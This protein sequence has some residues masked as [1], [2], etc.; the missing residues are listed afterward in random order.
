VRYRTVLVRIGLALGLVFAT[1]AAAAQEQARP[2]IDLSTPEPPAE[3]GSSKPRQFALG[4]GLLKEHGFGVV[5]R[6]RFDH[7]ALDA[8]YGLMPVFVLWRDADLSLV[9]VNAGPVI[10]FNDALDRFQNGVRIAGIY[11]QIL[12]PG[13]GFGWVGE[14]TKRSFAVGLGAGIQYYPDSDGRIRRHFHYGPGVDVV[15]ARVQ[16]YFGVNLLWYL[17]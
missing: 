5:G 16:L 17:G 13:A 11:D 10:F 6:V 8:A 3:E 1:T 2:K 9:H 7:L 12:G 14:F 15:S 4:F